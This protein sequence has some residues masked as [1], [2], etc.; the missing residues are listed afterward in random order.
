MKKQWQLATMLFILI[1]SLALSSFPLA[2]AAHAKG[3]VRKIALQGSARYPNAKGAAKYKVDSAEREFQVEV[4]NIKSLAGKRLYVYVNGVR[5][6]SF[7]V[8][9]LGIGRINRNTTRGRAVPTIT[10]GSRVQVKT[11]TG[12]LVVSGKF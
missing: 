10:A 4:E 12:I 8:S 11:G 7:L 3:T 2:Q 6:G 9:S 1:A 5:V